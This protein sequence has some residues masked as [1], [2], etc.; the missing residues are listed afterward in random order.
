MALAK[1]SEC[2]TGF[3]ILGGGGAWGV[4]NLQGDRPTQPQPEE[5]RCRSDW[6]ASRPRGC[7]AAEEDTPLRLPACHVLVPR[8]DDEREQLCVAGCVDARETPRDSDP[9]NGAEQPCYSVTLGGSQW[10]PSS[11]FHVLGGHIRSKLRSWKADRAIRD[12]EDPRSGL[13]QLA[14]D[15]EDR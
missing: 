8:G 3:R 14:G 5:S 12:D 6:D 11:R 2:P 10:R 9:G 1:D 7:R 4:R 13:R 15:R